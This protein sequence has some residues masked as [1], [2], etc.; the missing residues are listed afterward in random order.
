MPGKAEV[1]E[2][3]RSLGTVEARTALTKHGAPKP[4]FGVRFADIDALA[5]RYRGEHE[6]ACELWASN[7]ID[8]RILAM[9]IADPEQMS[10]A[11]LDRWLAELRWY[12]GV[13]VFVGSLVARSKHA[14]QKATTWRKA[15]AE[16][17]GRAGWSLIAH[18][19]RDPK[20]PDAW[21]ADC[22]DEI[23]A[24]IHAAK[25]RKREAMNSALIAIGGYREA[26]RERALAAAD[27]IGKV[28]IDHGETYC[29]TPEARPYIEAMVARGQKKTAK[30]KTAKK[31]TANKKRG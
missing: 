10:A 25:N 23:A 22:I 27:Q 5:K 26:L 14:Q 31:K 24:G 7:N 16:L 12:M 6:L 18:L 17:R 9:K 28:E 8:A 4:L 11:E 20:L 29:K 30:K 19:A 13:D 3:L 21:F 1:L 15:R 2:Q